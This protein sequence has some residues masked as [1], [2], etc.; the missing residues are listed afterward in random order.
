MDNIILDTSSEAATYRTDISGWISS[1]GRF[2]GN[3]ERGARYDGSTHSAC[4]CGGYAKHPYLICPECLQKKALEN[5]L[6]LPFEEWVDEPFVYS[7]VLDRYLTDD[8]LYDLDE[9]GVC[10]TDELM[11]VHCV[12]VYFHPIDGGIWT[13]LLPEDGE[14]PDALVKA[15]DEF[16]AVIKTLP[17]ASY[18]P[19]SVRT[20]FI[21]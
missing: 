21:P 5:Y 17:P 7:K 12:P 19:D 3:D 16:N 6:A 18:M 4:A 9:E 8:E 13:D 2:F 15:M 11:L 20:K 10:N 1:K 14:L